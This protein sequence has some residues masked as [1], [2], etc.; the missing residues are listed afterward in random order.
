MR[1]MQPPKGGLQSDFTS[2]NEVGQLINY[3][4][5]EAGVISTLSFNRLDDVPRVDARRSV[6]AD[7]TTGQG[8]FILEPYRS[9]HGGLETWRAARATVRDG[10]QHV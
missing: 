1:T 4:R 9:S 10:R 3:A 8:T 5:S 6:G 2:W 7:W